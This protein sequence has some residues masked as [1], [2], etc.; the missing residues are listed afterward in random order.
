MNMDVTA[1]KQTK[2]KPKMS[3]WKR[4]LGRF[5]LLAASLIFTA[6]LLEVGTRIFSTEIVPIVMKDPDVGIR[7]LR[8]FDGEIYVAESRQTVSIRTTRDGFRGPD[9]PLEKA[10]GVRRVAVLGDSM[11]AAIGVQERDTLCFQLEQQLN[12]SHP[13]HTWEVLN[14]GVDASSP[15]QELVLYR[16]I[17]AAYQP[18]LVICA[19]FA[20]NDL[21]DNSRRLSSHNR[22]YLDLDHENNLYQLPRSANR[23]LASQWLNRNSR[24]YLWQK[25]AQRKIAEGLRHQQGR[26]RTRDWTH[27]SEETEDLAHAWKLSGRILE[28]MRDEVTADGASFAVMLLPSG[29]QVYKD[30]FDEHFSVLS[31]EQRKTFEQDYQDRR[32]RGLCEES[33]IVFCSMLEQFRAAAPG[34][35]TKLEKEWLF[36][37]GK[38]HFNEKGNALAARVL[39]QFLTE[40]TPEQ[41]ATRPIIELLR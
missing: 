35:S 21:A 17:V 19:F 40:G 13:D 22:I 28:Q 31:E 24:F 8:S 29:L 26:I 6:G 20:G 1:D 30:Y 41:T 7:Y 4:I 16:K 18:D 23:A 11:I 27:C 25:H 3:R 32:L 34:A 37:D 5:G 2:Q 33:G 9:R 14:F 15:G 38:Y 39:H 10:P 12:K 36:F